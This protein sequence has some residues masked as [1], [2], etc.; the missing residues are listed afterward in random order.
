MQDTLQNQAEQVKEKAEN[1]AFKELTG[2]SRPVTA[3]TRQTT[4]PQHN[5]KTSE[6]PQLKS[7]LLRV[8][9]TPSTDYTELQKKSATRIQNFYKKRRNKQIFHEMKR[10]IILAESGFTLDTL[11]KLS[12]KD[13]EL[14][15]D[16]FIRSRVRFRFAG[17][18]FPPSI[19]Y[20]IFSK[21]INVHY[22]SAKKLIQPGSLAAID[23]CAM[24]G[25]RK[26]IEQ[27]LIDEMYIRQY[28]YVDADNVTNRHE[29]V[30]H[31]NRLDEAPINFGGRNNLW[32]ELDI[33]RFPSHR[34]FYNQ[35]KV[36]RA[37][38][39][40]AIKAAIEERRK[41]EIVYPILKTVGSA[42]TNKKVRLAKMMSIY[43]FGEI[44][45]IARE[46]DPDEE[47]ESLYEWSKDLKDEIL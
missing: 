22:V 14:L 26:F 15:C 11:R 3:S 32:R 7:S 38:G 17:E 39:K 37:F 18:S 5:E 27:V 47:F 20:K 2:F 28:E 40:K 13:F 16:P 10:I 4:A 6:T 9:N 33:S 19:M 25:S 24:M 36:K 44:G 34:I 31:M 30:K 42:K 1:V 21:G 29:F 23:S 8:A 35:A 46:Q 43:G 12:P 45:T 41:I